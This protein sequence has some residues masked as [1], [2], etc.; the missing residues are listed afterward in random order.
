MGSSSGKADRNE[1]VS[2][3]GRLPDQGKAPAEALQEGLQSLLDLRPGQGADQT[4][5]LF[6]S[7]DQ[8]K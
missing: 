4:V 8:E 7:T 2:S 3:T 5:D 1:S 6:S